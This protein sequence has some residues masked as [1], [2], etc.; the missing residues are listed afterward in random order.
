MNNNLFIEYLRRQPDSAYKRLWLNEELLKQLIVMALEDS[1]PNVFVL[2]LHGKQWTQVSWVDADGK[3]FTAIINIKWSALKGETTPDKVAEVMSMSHAQVI[4]LYQFY[5]DGIL[6]GMELDPIRKLFP[7]PFQYEK[8]VQDELQS[9]YVVPILVFVE[10]KNCWYGQFGEFHRHTNYIAPVKELN[11]AG[12]SNPLY[13]TPKVVFKSTAQVDCNSARNS[14]LVKGGII[15]LP[16]VANVED[17]DVSAGFIP[18][19]EGIRQMNDA[20][21]ALPLLQAVAEGWIWI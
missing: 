14:A 17:L 9:G 21:A 5:V 1:K 11:R 8:P 15:M 3:G 16:S 6:P 13:N 12:S 2:P 10:N 7:A 18:L 19:K 20:Q 4:D